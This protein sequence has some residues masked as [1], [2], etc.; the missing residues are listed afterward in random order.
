M[1]LRD[2]AIVMR[3][4]SADYIIREDVIKGDWDWLWQV[5]EYETGVNVEGSLQQQM[6]QLANQSINLKIQFYIST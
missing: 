6:S 3:L 1:L 2:K 5:L 4:W